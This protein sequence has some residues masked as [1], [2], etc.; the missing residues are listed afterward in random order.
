MLLVLGI[1]LAVLAVTVTVVIGFA[2][3]M[4]DAPSG[5][6]MSYWPGAA[7]A[8]AA[9]ACFVLRHFLAGKSITW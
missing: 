8:L 1:I 3:G 5:S 4:S 7:L 2:N 9:V 6:G